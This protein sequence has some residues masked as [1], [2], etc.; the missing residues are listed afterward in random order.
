[1]VDTNSRA[2]ELSTAYYG[3]YFQMHR[4]GKLEEYKSYEITKETET[5]WYEA[6][7]AKTAS[8]LSIRNWDAVLV[9]LSI[10]KN[11]SDTIILDHVIIFANRHVKSSDSIV[12]LMYAENMI[13]MIKLVRS[14]ASTELLHQAYKSAAQLLDDV[15]SSPLI[16]DPGHDLKSLNVKDK[17]SMNHRAAKNIETIK[18]MLAADQ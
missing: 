10:A 7:I 3:N 12:K 11:Y 8:E 18:E 9:L 4:D 1:M 17:K 6:M 5:E 14:K 2:Q 13:E 15:M 16:I